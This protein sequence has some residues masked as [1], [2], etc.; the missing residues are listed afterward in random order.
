MRGFQRRVLGRGSSGGKGVEGWRAMALGYLALTFMTPY[1]LCLGAGAGVGEERTN[2]LPC[3][4]AT[5]N[6]P[7]ASLAFRS[8]TCFL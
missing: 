2:L 1:V 3:C 8:T 4:G 6:F 5:A 7:G